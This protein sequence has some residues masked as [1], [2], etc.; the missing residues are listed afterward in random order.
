MRS[1]VATTWAIGALM[2]AASWADA[3]E[4]S[5]HDHGP[6]GQSLGKLGKVTF[7]TSCAPEAG[8]RFEQ[9]IAVLH[10][11]WWEEGDAAFN[12]VVEADSDCA[13][14]YWGLAMNAWGN[15]FAGG[16]TGAALPRGAEA[17]SKAASLS[18]GTGTLPRIPTSP[19]TTPS[20]WWPRLPRP[21]PPL[22]S[23]SERRRS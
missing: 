22:P 16:P 23:R 13:M 9:A 12:R 17:A 8:R 5:S 11:F 3:Q 7:V 18:A 15:P 19:S 14:A 2:A 10:S 6:H 20:R 4:P 1:I 21:T